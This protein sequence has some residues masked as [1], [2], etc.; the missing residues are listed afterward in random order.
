M[1]TSDFSERNSKFYDLVVSLILD[2]EE[3]RYAY[4]VT[5]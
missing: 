3:C 2:L 1:Y 4:G 5:S